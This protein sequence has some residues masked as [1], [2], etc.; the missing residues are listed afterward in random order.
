[1][2]LLNPTDDVTTTMLRPLDLVL[3]Q[4]SKYNE[5]GR[6]LQSKKIEKPTQLDDTPKAKLTLEALSKLRKY[7]ELKKSENLERRK[8]ASLMYS[9]AGGEDSGPAL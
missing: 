6:I 5:I 1:M 3:M 9:K 2:I 8:L 7:R 4:E